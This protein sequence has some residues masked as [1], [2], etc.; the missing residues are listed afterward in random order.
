MGWHELPLYWL[1][2]NGPP[3]LLL[4]AFLARRIRAVG[5]RELPDL[6][7]YLPALFVPRVTSACNR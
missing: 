5:P 7:G 3:S 6:G 1:L 4:A 2:I